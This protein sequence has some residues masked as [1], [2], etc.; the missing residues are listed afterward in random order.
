MEE[1]FSLV[2]G[3]LLGIVV[4]ISL[5]WIFA[6]V[7]SRYGHHLRGR[8]WI[9]VEINMPFE[10]YFIIVYVLLFVWMFL[11]LLIVTDVVM[12]ITRA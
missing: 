6:E 3:I 8:E 12:T 10:A 1:V 7:L 2:I 9:G 11:I 5:I 4:G